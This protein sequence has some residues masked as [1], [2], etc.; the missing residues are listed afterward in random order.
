MQ[1]F[2][3]MGQLATGSFALP[4]HGVSFLP[5]PNGGMELL[6]YATSL[7][8]NLTLTPGGLASSTS[9]TELGA[10]V[11]LGPVSLCRTK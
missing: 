8:T 11:A 2:N 10:R 1:H 3:I 4:L 5:G 7:A 9:P 6:H